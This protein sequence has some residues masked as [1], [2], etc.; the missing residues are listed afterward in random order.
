MTFLSYLRPESWEPCV[1]VVPN[2][3]YTCMEVNL[4]KVP[5]NIPSS[6]ENL[7]LSFNPLRH[8]ASHTFSNLTQLHVLDLSRCEIQIIEEDA[9][10]E[11]NHLSTLILTGNPIQHLALRTFSGLSSLQKLV[12][13]EINLE[14][15]EDFPIGHLKTLKEL[16][17]AHNYIHS[18]KLPEYFSNLSNL[19]LLDLSNNQIKKIY[20]KDLQV[21]HQIPQLNLSLD[22]SLNR[23]EFIQVGTFKE[24][25]LY[26]LTLRSNFD[27]LDV[28]KMCIQGLAGLEVHQLVLGEFK[29]ERTLDSFN[30]SALEGLCNVT[31]TGFR[32]ANLGEISSQDISTFNCLANVSAISL[33][34]LYL[35]NFENLP[36][37]FRWKS[38]ELVNCQFDQ[39][40]KLALP[41]LRKFV[42]TAS[43]DGNT[44]EEFELPNL[45]FLDLSGIGLRYRSCCS[46]EDLGTTR[47]KHLD[48]SFNDVI[49]M[50]SNFLGL[51]DLEYLDFQH[52]NLK[53][54]NDFSVFLSLRKLT[55]LDISYTGTRI[56]F[57]GIFHG[58]TNL[59]TLK[60]A[61]NFFQNNTLPGIFTG[62][63][64]LT[65]LDLSDCQLEQ[66]SQGAFDSLSRL[67]KINMSYNKLLS[68]DMLPYQDL[69][70]LQVLDYS[71][72]RIMTAKMHL[73][74]PL[75][76]NLT[77]LNMT[78]NDFVCTC[79]HQSFLQWVKDQ[80]QLL[81]KAEQMVC[82]R[83]SEMEGA[84]VLSF[85]NSTCQMSKTVIGM[86]V[87]AVLMVSLIFILVYKFY[88]HLM[89][90]AG[91]KKYSRGECTYDAFVIYSSQDE[92]WVR[93]ELVKNLEEGVPPF[94]L[95][96][97]YRD[98]IPGVAISSNI[99]QE[100]FHKSR[101]V[102][103]VVSQHFIQSR[104]CLFE[105]EI[106][107]TWQFL[108]SCSGII[109]IILQKVEKSL[110][111][112][113]VELYRLL[114]RNTYLEWEN[115]ALGQHIFWR[116]LRKALLV[117]KPWSPEETADAE[118]TPLEETTST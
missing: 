3:T 26:K 89:L 58:L 8:L 94:K 61:G 25:S 67:Q 51:D 48:L 60:M 62:L 52:S 110:L 97:H 44:F 59:R 41:S 46:K 10:Q 56:I 91:C 111:R 85:E 23:L 76:S 33:V 88:F 22:L 19:E 78:Q 54:A 14:S 53:Q 114:N 77:F 117:G 50:S 11:L 69:P 103:V 66:V 7:D 83:P 72:N 4:Y 27:S 16:N 55:Y 57:H 63:H 42:F 17:I 73:L 28:M 80:R 87:F 49:T 29:N 68:L 13:V 81:V 105:Y 47:L 12:A 32:I 2:V 5:D 93:N 21:L 101:K 106:A 98:F 20:H 36:K 116:R 1:E 113:Q 34:S 96:L 70:S 39:F 74:E 65:F 118:N 104:W 90:L 64:K 18:L 86:S 24:I 45:E 112:Q 84:P 75:P 40:P 99:I 109:F 35:E 108:S 115:N 6:T 71:F 95:C 79:E 38:L 43:R 31:I 9:F 102:L 15:L 107:Q 92:D 30:K 37:D 100:G 82:A